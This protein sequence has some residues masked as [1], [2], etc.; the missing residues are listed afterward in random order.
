MLFTDLFAEPGPV[1]QALR[2]LRHGGHDVILFHILD[3]AE[4]KFPF[5]GLIEFEEPETHEKLQI[6]AGTFRADY[7]ERD[8][9]ILRN[10]SPRVFSDR[11]RLRAARYEHAV[12]SGFDRLPGQP[13]REVLMRRGDS[14]RRRDST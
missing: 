6:D 9:G 8:P 12:R 7:L 4:A 11:H 3:E 10:V 1:I 14:T 2:R 5:D 13:S